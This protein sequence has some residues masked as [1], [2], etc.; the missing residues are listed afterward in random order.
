M[1]SLT[2]YFFEYLLRAEQRASWRQYSSGQDRHAVPRSKVPPAPHWVH[3]F[4]EYLPCQNTKILDFLLSP[5]LALTPSPAGVSCQCC[6]YV[7]LHMRLFPGSPC[8]TSLM[9]TFQMPAPTL[10]VVVRRPHALHA[11]LEPP[12]SQ[13]IPWGALVTIPHSLT[14]TGL[15][16]LRGNKPKLITSMETI[17]GT[18]ALFI[19]LFWSW[20]SPYVLWLMLKCFECALPW[21][22][23][24]DSPATCFFPWG[25]SSSL[26]HLPVLLKYLSEVGEV[27]WERSNGGVTWTSFLSSEGIKKGREIIE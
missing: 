12:L 9:L 15:T 5:R 16:S 21:A 17:K 8:W 20:D 26:D 19:H 13:S 2:R 1:H 14:V 23:S 4:P 24:P 3:P 10:S 25:V 22:V 18:L 6:N 27:T 7:G 11:W